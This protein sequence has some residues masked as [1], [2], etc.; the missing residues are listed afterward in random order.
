MAAITTTDLVL[1]ERRR[2]VLLLTRTIAQR[3]LRRH[4]APAPTFATVGG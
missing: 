1:S 4:A 2:A 3:E